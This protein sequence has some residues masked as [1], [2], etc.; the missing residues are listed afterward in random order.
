MAEKLADY[1]KIG[2]LECWLVS[3]EAETVEVLKL[4]SDDV[5]RLG[6]FGIGDE[7]RSE[8]LPDLT[9]QVNEIFA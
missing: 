1:Q 8:V 9:L 7:I 5:E 6:I 4:E 2:V 3:P